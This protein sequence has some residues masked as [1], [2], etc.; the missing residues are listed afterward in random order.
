MYPLQ[1]PAPGGLE[2]ILILLIFVLL[3]VIP[4][5]LAYWVYK[6]ATSRGDD[7]AVVWAI[8]VGGLTAVTLI[9]GIVALV[10]YVLQRD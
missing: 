4:I 1:A 10:V 8:A 5:G 3:L 2:L 9:G 7:N 6:D